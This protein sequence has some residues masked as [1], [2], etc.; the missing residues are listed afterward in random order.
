MCLLPRAFFYLSLTVLCKGACPHPLQ[1]SPTEPLVREM[2]VYRALFYMSMH[3]KKKPHSRPIDPSFSLFCP[4]AICKPD[5][6][7]D[8]CRIFETQIQSSLNRKIEDGSKFY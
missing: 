8:V 4:R 3:R 7:L 1:V 5:M 2:P 6:P